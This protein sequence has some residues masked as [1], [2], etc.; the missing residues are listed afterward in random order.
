MVRVA[1]GQTQLKWIKSSNNPADILT[2]SI[3]CDDFIKH[4]RAMGLEEEAVDSDNED[5]EEEVVAQLTPPAESD[6]ET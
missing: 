1:L 2:K 5:E 3:P 6:P 4:C